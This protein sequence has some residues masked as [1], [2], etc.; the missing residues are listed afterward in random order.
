MH[1]NP[2]N[3]ECGMNT[4]KGLNSLIGLALT[5][6]MTLKEWRELQKDLPDRYPHWKLGSA[7]TDAYL[8]AGTTISKEIDVV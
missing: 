1:H 8:T 5:V 3:R 7:I 4:T 2:E 6:T